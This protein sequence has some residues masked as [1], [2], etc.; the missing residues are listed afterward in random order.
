MPLYIKTQT[1]PVSAVKQYRS[2]AKAFSFDWQCSRPF[3]VKLKYREI[4]TNGQV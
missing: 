1:E 3:S 4:D 2:S